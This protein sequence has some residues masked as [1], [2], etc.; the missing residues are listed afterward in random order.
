LDE[1]NLFFRQVPPAIL[2]APLFFGG[3]YIVV[4]AIILRRG[5]ER[6]R[7]RREA[8]FTESSSPPPKPKM[9]VRLDANVP[10]PDLD[11]LVLPPIFSD[12]AKLAKGNAIPDQ[13]RAEPASL[14]PTTTQDWVSSLIPLDAPPANLA[15]MEILMPTATQPDSSTGQAPADA[16]EVM[17]VWRDV[18]DGSLIVQIG[19]KYYRSVA[20]MNGS[21]DIL[22]RFTAVAQQLWGMVTA[23]RST[24]PPAI[25]VPA[26]IGGLPAPEGAVGMKARIGL[27]NQPTEEPQPKQG[28]GVLRNLARS[29]TGASPASKVEK[30]SDG[31]ADAVEEYLQF[32]LSTHP[33]YQSRSI[34]IRPAIDGSIRIEVDGHF[35]DGIGDVVDADVRD[36]MASV[37]KE[38][39]ARQ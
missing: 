23:A 24:P 13:F 20:E 18:S 30:R 5:A 9:N 29:A 4:L 7:K 1:L 11:M 19:G 33:E 21:P 32:R 3:L 8:M 36:F 12:P 2:I 35:Y 26:G 22:K 15:P 34:H 38:W 16:V 37:M 27:L 14:I 31:I 25:D 39:E 10:E 6:R 17:R 28:G